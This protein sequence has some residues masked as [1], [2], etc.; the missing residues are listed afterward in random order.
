VIFDL[1][2]QAVASVIDECGGGDG[3]IYVPK[4]DRFLYG[5]LLSFPRPAA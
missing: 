4:I 5:A 2:T 3:A 1:T